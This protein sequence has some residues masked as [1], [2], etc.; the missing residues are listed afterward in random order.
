MQAQ[1]FDATYSRHGG[2]AQSVAANLVAHPTKQTWRDRV[3]TYMAYREQAGFAGTTL[4]DACR[5]FN[6]ERGQLSGRFTD[7]SAAGLIVRTGNV[8]DGF[9]EYRIATQQ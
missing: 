8:L 7:L 3:L 4:L 5:A 2:N 6:K 9:A 1:L